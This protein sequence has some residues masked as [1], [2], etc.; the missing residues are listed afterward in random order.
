MASYSVGV[1]PRILVAP[2]EL[3]EGKTS[4]RHLWIWGGLYMEE[5]L[6]L[7]GWRPVIKYLLESYQE[8][9]IVIVMQG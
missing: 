2:T 1:A 8:R 6:M 5:R 4:W 7:S 3:E 9:I